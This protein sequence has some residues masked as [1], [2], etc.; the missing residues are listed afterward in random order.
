VTFPE[1]YT[2]TPDDNGGHEFTITFSSQGA[3]I[4]GVQDLTNP[5]VTSGSGV[6]TVG[7]APASTAASAPPPMESIVF[8]GPPSN[9]PSITLALH[10]PTQVNLVT[11]FTLTISANDSNGLPLAGFRDTVHL[12]SSGNALLPRDYT[13]TAS[14]G[15]LKGFT[16]VFLLPGSHI[17][18]AQDLSNPAVNSGSFVVTGNTAPTSIAATPSATPSA[19]APS[20]TGPP[21]AAANPSTVITGTPVQS[22]P[23]AA[24]GTTE[25]ALATCPPGRT[26]LSGGGVVTTSDAPANVARVSQNGSFPSSDTAANASWTVTGAVLTDLGSNERMSVTAYAVCQ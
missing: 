2:F 24:A 9:G 21:A 23:G 13:F 19:V 15:G 5:G 12:T 6:T 7:A 16:L 18:G 10:G 22:P 25:K 20:G 3:Q 8:G 26:L 4:I 1:D 17:V 14:D 11:P